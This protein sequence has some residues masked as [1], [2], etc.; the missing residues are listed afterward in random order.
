MAKRWKD[1]AKI[2]Q[3]IAKHFQVTEGDKRLVLNSNRTEKDEV[4]EIFP[5]FLL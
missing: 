4:W 1:H 5:L 3:E 2:T